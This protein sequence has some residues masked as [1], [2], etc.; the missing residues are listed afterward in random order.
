M[1]SLG[2]R[3]LLCPLMTP[4]RSLLTLVPALLALLA[5]WFFVPLRSQSGVVPWRSV[6]SPFPMCYHHLIQSM[7]WALRS[8]Q[9][10]IIVVLICAGAWHRVDLQHLILTTR[11][12]FPTPL[13][14]SHHQRK[15][16]CYRSEK[17]HRCLP[18]QE[19]VVVARLHRGFLVPVAL[20][21]RFFCRRFSQF[22]FNC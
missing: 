17:G 11:P 19:I 1:T 6:G 20:V 4:E 14:R 2:H 18:D 9:I 5:L 7:I 8:I 21:G 13:C 12:R 10:R 16:R 22:D 3:L 15:I